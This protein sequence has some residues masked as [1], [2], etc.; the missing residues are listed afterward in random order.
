[1]LKQNDN[2][3]HEN[4]LMKNSILLALSVSLGVAASVQADQTY[5]WVDGAPGYTGT[6]VLDSSSSSAGSLSDIVS[7]TVNTPGGSATLTQANIGA[8]YVDNFDTTFA[9]TPSQISSMWIDW[10][11]TSVASISAGAAGVGEDYDTSGGLNFESFNTSTET[12]L[13]VAGAIEPNDKTGSWLA[14]SSTTGA[15][16]DAGSTSL[17]LGVALTGFGACRRFGRGK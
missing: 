9:W 11:T 1:L 16:P 14:T 17:L 15:V 8:V 2:I 3:T 13:D 12:N 6:I 4:T 5:S 10:Y 7:I